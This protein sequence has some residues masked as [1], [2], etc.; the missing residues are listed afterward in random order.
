MTQAVTYKAG[1][2]C[3]ILHSSRCV[4]AALQIQGASFLEEL[5]ILHKPSSTLIITDIAFNFDEACIQ[6]TQPGWLFKAYLSLSDGYR[7]CCTTKVMS[8]MM[9]P[10][11]CVRKTY[12][13]TDLTQREGLTRDVY[14]QHPS[15]VDNQLWYRGFD[16]LL[17][18]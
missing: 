4:S 11:G 2:T 17:H 12:I 6:T 8:Y 13:Q 10:G 5:A 1:S 7:R 9:D 16:L 3:S 15:L 18:K 14:L